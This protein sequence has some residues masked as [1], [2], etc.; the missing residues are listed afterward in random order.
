MG[1]AEGMEC[2]IHGGSLGCVYQ[3]PGKGG[4]VSSMYT[5]PLKE[6]NPGIMTDAWGHGKSLGWSAT[7][8]AGVLPVDGNVDVGLSKQALATA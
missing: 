6:R 8:K 2:S 1:L 3:G 4:H 5:G 7:P